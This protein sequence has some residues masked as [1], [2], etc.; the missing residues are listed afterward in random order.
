MQVGEGDLYRY[1]FKAGLYQMVRAQRGSHGD[2]VMI[3]SDAGHVDSTNNIG[4]SVG[5]NGSL[6]VGLVG[7][8]L[9]VRRRRRW[10][11]SPRAGSAGSWT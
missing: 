7:L 10:P 3:Q 1:R 8:G 4:C 9:V 11:R 2:A 5:G 6:A